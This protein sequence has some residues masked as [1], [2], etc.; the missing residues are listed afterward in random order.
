MKKEV[1]MSKIWSIVKTEK[2]GGFSLSFSYKSVSLDYVC[3]VVAFAKSLDSAGLSNSEIISIGVENDIQISPE[4]VEK[5]LVEEI[6][7]S[8]IDNYEMFLGE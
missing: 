8:I 1:F 4:E 6:K 7:D 3:T 5:S 2:D